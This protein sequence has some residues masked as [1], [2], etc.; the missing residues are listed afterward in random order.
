MTIPIFDAHL[1]LA[2][3]ATSFNRD[4]TRSLLTIREAEAHCDDHP[5][6]GNAVIS[7]PELKRAGLSFCVATL[8]ARSGPERHN[9]T[10][11]NRIDLDYADQ[12]IASAVAQGQLAYYRILEQE[13][14]LVLIKTKSD[15]LQHW[16]RWQKARD[17]TPPG[18]ILS[19]EGT[20]PIMTPA[21][22][23]EWFK[24]GLRAAG[25]AHYGRSQH[26]S[27]TA[28]SGSVTAAG[29]ELLRCFEEQGIALDVTHLCD[30]SM[31][32]AL[33]LFGGPVLASHH[34]CRSLVPGD[35]QITDRHIKQLVLRKGVIGLSLD[36]WMLEPGWRRD[37]PADVEVSLER[38]VDHID[39]MCQIAGSTKH[40]AIGSDLDGGFGNERTP[41][42]LNAYADVQRLAE[43]LEKRNYSTADI[44]L[45][46]YG[47]WLRFFTEALPD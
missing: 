35:R 32:E 14:H 13:G 28:T 25:I 1:D 44:E 30:Q 18:I 38:A 27:G 29:K 11:T 10:P 5:A 16:E 21:H 41:L 2:W 8:L 17:T 31:D 43:F 34:N 46:F 22:A 23:G 20:D 47:N 26:A 9:S 33:S 7:L 3:N 45:I 24:Y 19:M 36:C 6:R 4:L 39:H 42:E 15:L 40:V 37:K 12:T